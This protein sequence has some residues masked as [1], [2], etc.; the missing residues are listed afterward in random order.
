MKP[1]FEVSPDV[2]KLAEFLESRQSATYNEM[3]RRIGRTVNGTDRYV[4][5]GALRH[6]Q[7]EHGFIFVA[8]R[9]V[10]VKRATNG[11]VATLSTDHAHRKVGRTVRRAKK[12][13][14]HVNTQELTNDERDAFYI[15]TAVTQ[16][17]DA[18]VGRKMRSKIAHEL[19]DRNGEA[20]DVQDVIALFRKRAH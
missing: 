13:Q 7:R 5:Y 6:L 17:L 11:Q 19:H 4:L 3:N 16:I 2:R 15:G 20:V 8:E 1:S 12:L 9:G 10:G 18:A 14:T